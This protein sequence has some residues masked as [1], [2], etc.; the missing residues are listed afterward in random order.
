MKNLELF[1]THLCVRN[2]TWQC[3]TLRNLQIVTTDANVIRLLNDPR[4]K[5]FPNPIK[6]NYQ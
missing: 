1:M 6:E 5:Y 3:P 2:K 4:T